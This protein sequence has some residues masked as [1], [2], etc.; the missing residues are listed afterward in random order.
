MP[1]TPTATIR[2]VIAA[3]HPIFRDGL[4]RLLETEPQFHIVGETGPGPEAAELV[5]DL[6]PDILLLDAEVFADRVRA[7]MDANPPGIG[8][9]WASSLEAAMRLVAWC[10]TLQLFRRSMALT[11]DL[12][13]EMLRWMAIHATYVEKYLSTSFSPNTHVTGEALGL[14]YAGV[15]LQQHERAARWRALGRRILIKHIDR[16]VHR[17]GVCFEQSTYYQRYTVEIYLHFLILAARNGEAAPPAVAERLQRMLDFLLSVRHP[18]GSMPQIGDSDGG[19][20]LLLEARADDDLRGVFSTAA[21]FFQRADYAWAAGGPSLEMLGLLGE[22]GARDFGELEPAPPSRPPS[23]LFMGGEYVVMRSGWTPD[24]HHL[25]FDVGPLGCP[26]GAGHGHADLLSVQCAAFGEPCLADA[27]TYSYAADPA[28]RDFFRTSGAHSTVLVDGIGQAAPAGPF[29]WKA[30]PR[31][32]LRRWFSSEAYDLA[33]AD[34]NAYQVLSDPVVHRRRVLFVKPSYWVVVDDLDGAA[35]HSV[36]VRFQFAP[37]TVTS[38]AGPWTIVRGPAGRG[39][40]VTTWSTV[41]L[42]RSIVEGEVNPIGGW[43]SPTYGQ[44]RPAPM[45]RVAVATRLPLRLV[46]ALVPIKDSLANLPTHSELLAC[47]ASL[48]Y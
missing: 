40:A 18:N 33:D 8:I 43:V 14:F 20:L 17:D 4:R 21:A 26:H 6:E 37:F 42:E 47:V 5:H 15:V 28:W 45:L 12:V 25:I 13:A 34:H 41:R 19:W 39:L 2:I 30:R 3:S 7:W 11:S 16:Q 31:A 23:R 46:S 48:E 32:R 36:E 9:N 24:A 10:W 27:G 29:S 1:T 44:R 35:V 38:A 22:A